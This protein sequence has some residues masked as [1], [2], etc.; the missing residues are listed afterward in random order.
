MK[1]KMNIK[2]NSYVKFGLCPLALLTTLL[3]ISPYP[4]EAEHFD[5]MLR[6]VIGDKQIEAST[7]TTPPIGGV[8]KRPVL[9][10]KSGEFVKINWQLK[11]VFPH[12]AQKGVKV[13]FFIV[14]EA[15]LGQKPVPNPAGKAGVLD[16]AF[17]MDFSE[18]STASG[19]LKIKLP[20]PGAYLVRIQSESDPE[21]HDHEHFSALDLDVE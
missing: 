9:K 16:D 20:E 4:A 21:V 14:K 13:H 3:V 15:K 19:S 12:G 8:N 2:M 5:M 10:G 7:D 1:K 6:A 11:N 17:T 18:K